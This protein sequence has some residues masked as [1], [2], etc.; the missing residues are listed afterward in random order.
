MPRPQGRKHEAPR[1]RHPG[2][3]PLVRSRTVPEHVLAG[4][5]GGT[6]T[7]LAVYAVDTESD[8][9]PVR[10]QA[11][12]SKSYAGLE[13]VITEFLHGR[14]ERVGAAAFGVAGPVVDN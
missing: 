2:S 4:D 8:L 12:P 14:D 13:Q 1:A 9:V 6:K 11:F 10:E 7:V 3:R 5:I